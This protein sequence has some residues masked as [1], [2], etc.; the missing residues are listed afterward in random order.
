MP[1][2]RPAQQGALIRIVMDGDR[3]RHRT[4][5]RRLG[6]LATVR[7]RP[8]PFEVADGVPDPVPSATPQ[9][10]SEQ[11]ALAPARNESLPAGIH[12]AP[13]EADAEVGSIGIQAGV[14]CGGLRRP[15]PP[16]RPE[17][18]AMTALHVGR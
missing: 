4:L 14:A 17:D 15:D 13:R 3:P 1:N 8:C 5:G 16:R 11:A 6:G 10:L 12:E 18:T 2:S 9:Q 7:A